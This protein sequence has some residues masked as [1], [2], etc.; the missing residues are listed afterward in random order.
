[1]SPNLS[2]S[3]IIWIKRQLTSASAD[4]RASPDDYRD[5]TVIRNGAS[6]KRKNNLLNMFKTKPF[7]IYGLVFLVW[8]MVT[9]ITTGLVFKLVLHEA[10]VSFNQRV[11]QLHES[12]ELIARDNESVLEGFTAFLGA[13]EYADRESASRYAQQILA[14]YPHVY[15]LEVAL[16]VKRK[17]LAEFIARQKSWFPQFK[18]KAFSYVADRHTGQPVKKK[19]VYNPIIFIESMSPNTKQLIGADMDSAS[20]LRD[21]L[22]QS[23]KLQSSVATI[24]F[25]RV[26][27]PRGYILFRPVPDPPRGYHS[28][29][30]Q[31]LAL[32]EVNAEAIQKKIALLVENLD[33]RL[34]YAS[35]SSDEPEGMLLQIADSAP[36][37]RL[38]ARLFPKLAAERKLNSQGQPFALRVDK[39]LGWS[40][41]DLPLVIAAEST[42]LLF[43]ALML[44][45]LSTHLRKEEER[46]MSANQLLHMA[47]HDALTGLPNRTLLT[48]RFSQAC[49]RTQRR[50]MPF[51]TMFLDL[52]GFKK[53]NDT[54]GHEVGDQ[55]LKTLGDL[56]KECIRNEDTLSRISGDE[57]VI[58]L[59]NTSYEDAEKVARKIQ[60]KLTRPVLI[61]GIELKIGISLGIAVYPDDG[62]EMSDL[63]RKADARMYEAKE[64][65]KGVMTVLT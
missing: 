56:L 17:D 9:S 51:S 52:N 19:P 48:D 58:L 40:D 41:L 59:E 28:K 36:P 6:K 49:S 63:L 34:Y 33:F 18:M 22:N 4:Q 50:D 60:A 27:G 61:Q 15:A 55:L 12:I 11:A 30:K 47:T 35:Y 24:P 64:Q 16:I 25:T 2:P 53:V 26:G 8:A 44:L 43:L 1:M 23:K 3:W 57:F 29:R 21:A 42:S 20:F 54:Y 39:Q 45:S 5:C 62:T 46:K 13:I 38:K 65:S 32:L 10:E 31:A 37:N 14:R 7:W